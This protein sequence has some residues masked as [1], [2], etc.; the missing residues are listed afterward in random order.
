M[1]GVVDALVYG[2]HDPVIG[3]AYFTYL[4]D[5]SSHVV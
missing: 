3:F 4:R 1:N 2:W 5:L